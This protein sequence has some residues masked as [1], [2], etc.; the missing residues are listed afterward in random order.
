MQPNNKEETDVKDLMDSMTDYQKINN[1]ICIY[2]DGVLETNDVNSDHKKCR[3]CETI[4]WFRDDDNSWRNKISDKLIKQEIE[5]EFR[6]IISHALLGS[7][8]SDV[9]KETWDLAFKG[10]TD[11]TFKLLSKP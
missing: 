6:D 11:Y 7:D 1:S 10:I 5:L 3:E 4:Y 8:T 9:D 2:C